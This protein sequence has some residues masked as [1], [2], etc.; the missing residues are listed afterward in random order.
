MKGTNSDAMPPTVVA[1]FLGALSSL[2][3]VEVEVAIVSK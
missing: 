2:E 1:R 3:H